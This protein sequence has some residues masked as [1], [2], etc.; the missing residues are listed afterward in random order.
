L[1]HNIVDRATANK[2]GIYYPA[3]R[4]CRGECGD[5]RQATLE[6]ANEQRAAKRTTGAD[7]TLL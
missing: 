5:I 6:A 2:D 7:Q 3:Q 1:I 4:A